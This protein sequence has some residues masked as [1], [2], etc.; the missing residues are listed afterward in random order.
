MNLAFRATVL[1]KHTVGYYTCPNCGFMQTEPPYW[2]DEAYKNP[3]NISD[4]GIIVRNQR[5]ARIVAS[6]IFLLFDKDKKFVDYAGGYGLFTR[7]MRDIGFDF[8]WSDPYTQNVMARKFEMQ[9]NERYSIATS[10]E[11]FE[12]FVNPIEELEK[13][14][15][16]ADNVILSTEL[17]PNPV[18]GI[19]EWWYYGKEHGQHVA[20]YTKSAFIELSSRSNL[21]YYNV[22][23]IHILTKEK[24]S[25]LGRL[26]LKSRFS[27]YLLYALSFIIIPLLKSKTEEDMLRLKTENVGN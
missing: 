26:I 8:Y 6:I 10:F 7:M 22:D 27:K 14:L 23:N 16:V 9:A 21:H 4:T 12:H 11:S 2:L 25:I 17:L 20:F 24:F 3:I 19:D 1:R 15:Q 13:I 5:Q 18:P